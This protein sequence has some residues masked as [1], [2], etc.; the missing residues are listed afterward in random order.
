MRKRIWRMSE[1]QF[2]IVRPEVTTEYE[3]IEIVGYAG[4]KP[5]GS[6]VLRS[7][8]GVAM[9][10]V[11]YSTH[12]YV[13][14]YNPQFDGTEAIIRFGVINTGF[15]EGDV[16]SGSF[17]VAMNQNE[18]R[19]PFTISFVHR[20]PE[21]SVGE[22]VSLETFTEL[23][24]RH[25]NEAL[26]LFFSDRF[27]DYIRSEGTELKLLYKGFRRAVPASANLEEFLVAAGQKERVTFDVDESERLYYGVNENQKETFE[28][29]KNSWG[30]IA[31]DVSCDADFMTIEKEHITSDFFVGSRLSL[32]FYIHKDRLHAG[33]NH[34]V[35]TFR[36][37]G[38]VKRIHIMATCSNEFDT[39]IPASRLHKKRLLNLVNLYKEF[40][41]DAIL[42]EEW[43]AGSIELLNQMIEEE[44]DEGQLDFY[45]LQKAQA[46]IVGG[47]KEDA[48]WII[49]ELRRTIE[50]K[51][52]TDWAFLLYLCTL[53]EKEETYV[54]RLT[55]EI[56][57]LFLER[58]EDWRIFWFLLFLRKDYIDDPRRKLN[59]IRRW[60]M[61]GYESPYLYIEASYLLRQD[62]YLF[63]AFDDFFVKVLRWT[64]KNGHMNLNLSM[65]LEHVLE[66]EKEFREEVFAL[67]QGAYAVYPTEELI[68]NIIAYLLKSRKYGTAYVKWYALAIERGMNFTGLYEAYV[69]SIP[70]DTPDKLPEMIVLYFRY[71]NTLP[72]DRKA[73]VYANVLTYYARELRIYEQYIRNIEGFALE[74]M[75]RG[76]MDDNMAVIYR[77]I[78]FDRGLI[79]DDVADAMSTLLFI[80]KLICLDTDVRRIV[81]YE[82][83][84]KEPFLLPVENGCAFVPI[85]SRNF[86]VFLEDT[87]GR[88]VAGRNDYIIEE[89]FPVERMLKKLYR[90]AKE[91][92]GYFLYLLN[93]KEKAE[94]FREEEMN[95]IAAFLSSETVDVSY[96]QKMYPLI[97]SYL[98]DHGREEIV[99]EHFLSLKDY[100]G[101]DS[102]TISYIIDLN[103]MEDHYPKAYGLL[104]EYNGTYTAG[105]C[106]LR[107]CNHLIGEGEEK[108][109]DF[110]LGIC[111]RLMRKFL[112]SEDT[113]RFMNRYFI[114]PTAD[115]LTLWQ[116]ALAR[117][118]E[119]RALE[120]RILT[121]MLFT[122]NIDVTS[123]AV[124]KEYERHRGNPM[125]MEAYVTFWSYQYMTSKSKVPTVVFEASLA[126]F[127]EGEH[128]NESMRYALMKY[129][130]KKN[131]LSN[132]EYAALSA[133]IG[134]AVLRNVY[135]GFM[136]TM[137][138]SLIVK[139]HLYDKLFAEYHGERG[140]HL[141]IRY[142]KDDGEV[143]QMDMIEMYRGIYVRQFV[144]FFGEQLQ[145]EIYDAAD[146]DTV[147]Q[148]ETLVYQ[149][150]TADGAFDRY[151][152]LNRMQRELVYFS[153][154]E[155][156]ADMKQYKDLEF[157][158]DHLFSTL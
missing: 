115:M 94:D 99:E 12:P 49:Q 61:A 56:E 143:R 75:R 51:K 120:E 16:I 113:I 9:R 54:D 5:E 1:D 76:R 93:D 62:A 40:R 128:L 47:Q 117:Q 33:K 124:F 26:K 129:L 156:L 132:T 46:L 2:D 118:L 8:N 140:R 36:A 111:T 137:E 116:F 105:K 18:L 98:Q 136:R 77:H 73:Y 96:R 13:A 20:Y 39:I 34:A 3:R 67:A 134:E 133:L 86:R 70:M 38:V 131:V 82:E 31:I 103:I 126:K 138:H 50:D 32:A 91:R 83:Q 80:R 44:P 142:R 69:L 123:E 41:K 17:C 65:Q 43:A 144:C 23:C 102:A 25:W 153:E 55:R 37:P 145:Y 63:T 24:R 21:S 22:I 79:D 130:A 97:V 68:H 109:D 29:T 19:V 125:L 14:V 119:T 6:F 78:F 149:D 148:A 7:V 110:L 127:R 88:L 15:R 11:C 4:D 71:Q 27:L 122:E 42:T 100:D 72:I 57:L 154:K 35:V 147:L 112:S 85:Y 10:G 157:V 28:L 89:L 64:L 101:L 151:D 139:Y 45:R 53:I 90:M 158:T 150:V 141:M 95:D 59:D 106:L 92:T 108:A 81:V 60:I 146:E 107:M 52:S 48:L 114:G 30:Y 152:L 66:G 84:L 104:R 58:E 121:Q 74:Q 87:K 155:L 135:F